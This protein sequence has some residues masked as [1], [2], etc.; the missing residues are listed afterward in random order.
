[1]YSLLMYWDFEYNFEKNMIKNFLYSGVKVE[2][3]YP[4]IGDVVM[5]L[6]NVFGSLALITAHA[7]TC[8]Q[9]SFYF[10][11]KHILLWLVCYF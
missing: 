9:V 3:H 1:M 4:V 7:L 11:V 6:M 5:I 2:K 8:H 10:K